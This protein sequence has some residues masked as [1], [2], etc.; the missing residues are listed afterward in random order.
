MIADYV[1]IIIVFH[2]VDDIFQVEN[3][4]SKVTDMTSQLDSLEFWTNLVTLLATVVE[5]DKSVYESIF[6]E[7]VS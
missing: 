6:N 4:R 3:Q 1:V 2:Y 5:E 7:Y